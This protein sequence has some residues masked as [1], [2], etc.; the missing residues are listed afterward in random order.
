MPV[1]DGDTAVSW[2]ALTIYRPV[3]PMHLWNL[4]LTVA[5]HPLALPE[6][7][8]HE[9]DAETCAADGVTRAPDQ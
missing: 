6:A 1:H 4:C 8:R 9:Y 7:A 5:V 2:V 3:L